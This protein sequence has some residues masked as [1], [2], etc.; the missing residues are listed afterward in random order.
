MLV[1]AGPLSGKGF[2]M[3]P[4]LLVDENVTVV[5]SRDIFPSSV[6]KSNP[7][8]SPSVFACTVITNANESLYVPDVILVEPIC[9]PRISQDVPCGS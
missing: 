4:T 7:I 6:K 8:T 5:V 9:C 1:G 3:S 2:S